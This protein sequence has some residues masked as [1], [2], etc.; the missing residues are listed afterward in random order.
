MRMKEQSLQARMAF[1]YQARMQ[2]REQRM[3]QD[4][5]D[6][7]TKAERDRLIADRKRDAPIPAY[8]H[9]KPSWLVQPD[10]SEP[11]RQREREHRINQLQKR[12]Q[13]KA[14]LVKK[15]ET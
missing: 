1:R 2:S 4:K 8:N 3:E 6:I 15:E 9:P 13:V 12:L 7:A 5:P 14:V 10:H 11:I